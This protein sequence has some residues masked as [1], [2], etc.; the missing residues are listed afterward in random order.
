MKSSTPSAPAPPQSS[1]TSERVLVDYRGVDHCIRIRFA[2]FNDYPKVAAYSE[3]CAA[4]GVDCAD[5][6]DGYERLVAAANAPCTSLM[7]LPPVAGVLSNSVGDSIPG[8]TDD[9]KVMLAVLA[10]CTH[11][12]FLRD[13]A[14]VISFALLA[15]N[16]TLL[17]P[18]SWKPTP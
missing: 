7:R 13:G 15:R 1:S 3:L 4:F 16:V 10:R 5:P 18:S 8:L 2:P 17:I 9:T 6:N 12:A 14:P 11:H